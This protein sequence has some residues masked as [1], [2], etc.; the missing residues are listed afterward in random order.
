M[1]QWRLRV[2]ARFLARCWRGGEVCCGCGVGVCGGVG[3]VGLW[4]LGWKNEQ[5]ITRPRV[6]QTKSVG[7]Q[8]WIPRLATMRSAQRIES[9][10]K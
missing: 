6:T 7:D 10:G 3:K 8:L 1:V 9:S 5:A 2:L 4:V